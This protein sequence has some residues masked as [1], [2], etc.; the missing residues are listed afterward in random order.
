MSAF[1]VGPSEGNVTPPGTKQLPDKHLSALRSRASPQTC[2]LPDRILHHTR[3]T[4]SGESPHKVVNVDVWL[5]CIH[6]RSNLKKVL[7]NGGD[8]LE[9][10]RSHCM[11][12]GI[13]GSIH[14]FSKANV[15]S[16]QLSKPRGRGK[17]RRETFQQVS[18][19]VTTCNIPR[20]TE[21][22]K[23]RFCVSLCFPSISKTK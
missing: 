3:L 12:K 19:G 18:L 20:H 17:K 10:K 16:K 2:A 23:G 21:T 15:F 6:I 8:I 14:Y 11:I 7:F 1:K 13:S 9:V 22:L 5:L 4:Y